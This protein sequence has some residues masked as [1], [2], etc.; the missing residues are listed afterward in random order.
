MTDDIVI[1]QSPWPDWFVTQDAVRGVSFYNRV[2]GHRVE[3][4]PPTEWGRR[5]RWNLTE[6][7]SGIY[8]RN[9]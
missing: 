2:S 6:D 7:G 8:F 4:E 3:V 9:G 1:H 5:W